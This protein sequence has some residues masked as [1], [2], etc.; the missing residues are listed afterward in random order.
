[1]SYIRL[2]QVR[3]EGDSERKDIRVYTG[4]DAEYDLD[5]DL[6]F[7][8]LDFV[9]G[10]VDKIRDLGEDEALVIWKEIF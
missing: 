3:P 7:E 1:M 10:V 5:A 6:D 8:I 2:Q 9:L 4:G